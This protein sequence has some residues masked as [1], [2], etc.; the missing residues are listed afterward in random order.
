MQQRIRAVGAL[1]AYFGIYGLAL[2]WLGRSARFEAGE[3]LAVLLI[4]GVGF[5]LAA[6]ASAIGIKAPVVSVQ[7][8]RREWSATLIYLALFAVLFL[9]WGLSFLQTLVP[10]GR[11]QETVIL[12]AKLI[13]MVVLPAWLFQRLGYR[14]RDLVGAFSWRALLGNGQ[15]R[16]LL[17]MAI[18]LLGLQ[19]T[20]GRGPTQLAALPEPVWFIVAVAPLALLWMTLEAGLTEEFLFRA[21]LQTRA[22]AYLRSETAAIVVM[23]VLFG[24]VHAPGYVLREAHLMEGMAGAPDALTA[25]AYSIVV[26]SPIGLMFGVLWA[27]TRNFWLLVLLHGWTDLLPNLAPFIKTWFS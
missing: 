27:R 6:W 18:L 5:S 4:F 24:L 16:V 2:L 15:W 17:V 19:L 22:S 12:I 20:I 11:L 10:A 7:A 21:L 23:S 25:I 26:V 3:S 8:P 9:G 1:T 14:W 13:T